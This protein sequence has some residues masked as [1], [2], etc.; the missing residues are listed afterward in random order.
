MIYTFLLVR[1]SA[2][3]FLIASRSS[4][5]SSLFCLSAFLPLKLINLLSWQI[6]DLLYPVIWHTFPHIRKV[7]T[8]FIEFRH[9]CGIRC[10]YFC[11][12]FISHIR[13]M[14]FLLIYRYWFSIIFRHV[15]YPHPTHLYILRIL[16]VFFLHHIF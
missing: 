10:I 1:P 14:R 3:L 7:L 15:K 12:L 16:L 5:V 11:K 9:L 8:S 4:S 6:Y 2:N 13:N